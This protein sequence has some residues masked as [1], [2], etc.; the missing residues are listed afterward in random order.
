MCE[1]FK[2]D[3]VKKVFEHLD[4]DVI[5]NMETQFNIIV[6]PCFFKEE[7]LDCKQFYVKI[8]DDNE[9]GISCKI[10]KCFVCEVCRLKKTVNTSSCVNC[11]LKESVQNNKNFLRP[12]RCKHCKSTKIFAY[13]SKEWIYCET[14]NS[15]SPVFFE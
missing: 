5:H 11:Y 3:L 14:C 7:S 8:S 1:E 6:K 9:K 10:C 15:F 12:F 4:K 13:G 2:K